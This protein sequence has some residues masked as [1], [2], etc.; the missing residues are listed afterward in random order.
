[1]VRLGNADQHRLELAEL[2]VS[3]ELR[4]QPKAVVAPLL[5]T[6][7]HDPLRLPR[8]IDHLPA[9]AHE[10]RQRLFAIDVLPCAAGV[11]RHHGVPMIGD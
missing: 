5:R 9:F 2:A 11:D 4:G 8:D 6:G 3:R 1:V 7:L 10:E